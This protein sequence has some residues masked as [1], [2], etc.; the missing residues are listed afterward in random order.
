M[1][2]LCLSDMAFVG[3]AF[4]GLGK[5]GTVLESVRS[6]SHHIPI[7]RPRNYSNDSKAISMQENFAICSISSGT[8][9][10]YSSHSSQDDK[11]SSIEPYGRF[12]VTAS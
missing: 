11:K 4:A 9:D 6:T 2:T 8:G 5:H 12:P 7:A 1:Y 10:R 3:W